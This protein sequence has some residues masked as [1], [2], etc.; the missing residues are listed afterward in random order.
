[1]MSLSKEIC[2]VMSC[3]EIDIENPGTLYSIYHFTGIFNVNLSRA[4]NDTNS[5]DRGSMI[6]A[7]DD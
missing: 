5:T 7:C 3:I 6:N 1:M 2:V 4:R